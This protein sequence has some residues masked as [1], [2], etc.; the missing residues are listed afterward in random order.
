MAH[1]LKNEHYNFRL[2]RM[3]VCP[4]AK[5]ILHLRLQFC[6]CCIK[7]KWAFFSIQASEYVLTRNNFKTENGR[8]LESNP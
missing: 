7:H 8:E 5:L 1:L 3:S 6:K 2:V 4:W